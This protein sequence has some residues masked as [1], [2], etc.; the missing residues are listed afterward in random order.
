MD[1]LWRA[2][3]GAQC[4]EATLLRGPAATP[5]L[6]P[7]VCDSGRRRA[8]FVVENA[9]LAQ[10]GRYAGMCLDLASHQIQ[11]GTRAEWFGQKDIEVIKKRNERFS[12]PE[13]CICPSQRLMLT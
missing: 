12:L 4:D 3:G 7:Q 13:L 6:G 10:V 5:D 2:Y 1:V 8:S 9:R 11:G